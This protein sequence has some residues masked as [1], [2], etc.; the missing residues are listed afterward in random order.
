MRDTADS[1]QSINQT[2]KTPSR[3]PTT[4]IIQPSANKSNAIKSGPIDVQEKPS[5]ESK[6]EL[7]FP[8]YWESRQNASFSDA[9]K[10]K[11]KYQQYR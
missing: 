4:G 2:I 1:Q 5:A 8:I 11:N 9:S 10:W 7:E 6:H 3:T